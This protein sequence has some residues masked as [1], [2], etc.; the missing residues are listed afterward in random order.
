MALVGE[1]G[2]GERLGEP[3]C[4]GIGEKVGKDV[5]YWIKE[6]HRELKLDTW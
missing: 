3:Y 1:R 2:D 5:S 6:V 4:P